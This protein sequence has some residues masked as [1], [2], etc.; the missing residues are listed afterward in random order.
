LHDIGISFH[1]ALRAMVYPHLRPIGC[2]GSPSFRV[3]PIP[4]K[5]ADNMEQFSYSTLLWPPLCSNG[6]AIMFYFCDLLLLF[7]NFLFIFFRAVIFVAEE[8]RPAGPLAGCRNV[9]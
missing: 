8:H 1:R 3:H 7:I 9:V 5:F 4:T 6:Q 2:T